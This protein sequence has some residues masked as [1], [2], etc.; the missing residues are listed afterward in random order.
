[1][2]P[3]T[4]ESFM[5][6]VRVH[7]GCWLW[8]GTKDSKG[9]G[10]FRF[11]GQYYRAHRWIFEQK[12]EPI[13]EGMVLL[14]ACDNPSCVNPDHLTQGTQLANVQDRDAKGRRADTHGDNHPSARLNTEQVLA[15]RATR[16]THAEIASVYGVKSRTIRAIKNREIWGHV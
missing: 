3:N 4:L 6:R 16:G 8:E 12:C 11:H 2:R 5:A 9:Y 14:H 13:Q 1:M 15:I 7:D 10:K